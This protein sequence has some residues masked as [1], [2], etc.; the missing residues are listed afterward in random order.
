MNVYDKM[1]QYYDML[2]GKKEN[3]LEDCNFLEL[4]F[5]KYCPYKPSEILDIGCGTGNHAI[6]LVKRGYKVIGIDQSKRMI[7]EAKTKA[8]G[9]KNGLLF[10]IQNMKNIELPRKNDC[11]ICL[12]NSFG[13]LIDQND[14]KKFFY[15]LQNCL[16]KDSLFIFEFW[17]IGAVKP[18]PYK[19]WTKRQQENLVLYRL[20]TTNFQVETNILES[21]KEF[22]IK[23]GKKILDN[24]KEIHKLKC[25]T[26]F[27]IQQLLENNNF[28]LISVFNF[29]NKNKMKF[30]K[31][32]RET[33]RIAAIAKRK[34]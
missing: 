29:E 3:I 25:Y 14:L 16:K 23:D 8:T 17:N 32:K 24:F 26:I 28:Q 19:K 31:P 9:T 5:K 34:Q 7:E 21:E 13:Y 2:Y 1:A 20:E 27:E 15:R 22:I 18:T 11:A 4:A 6:E 33:F 12:F 10:F 30:K